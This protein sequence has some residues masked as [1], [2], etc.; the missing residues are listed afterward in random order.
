MPVSHHGW[1]RKCMFPHRR[2]G[3]RSPNPDKLSNDSG[4]LFAHLKFEIILNTY[5]AALS[6]WQEK[7]LEGR[8]DTKG[9]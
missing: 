7:K 6:P 5:L 9:T 4:P 3:G 8:K 1:Y 2:V